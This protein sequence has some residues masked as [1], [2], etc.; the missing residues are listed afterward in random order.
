[1]R[2]PTPTRTSPRRSRALPYATPAAVLDAHARRARDCHD[3]RT[4]RSRTGRDTRRPRSVGSAVPAR[5][6]T[7]S[8]GDFAACDEL[9][10]AV[11]AEQRLRGVRGV[12]RWRRESATFPCRLRRRTRT[13]SST[14][15]TRARIRSTDPLDANTARRRRT[16]RRSR[17]ASCRCCSVR[18]TS[19]AVRLLDRRAWHALATAF[20]VPA[21]GALVTAAAALGDAADSA[22]LGGLLTFAVGV[23]IGIVGCFGRETTLHDVGRRRDRL[24]RRVGRRRRRRTR[25]ESRQ[26]TTSDLI[27]AGRRRARVRP[28]RRSCSRGWRTTLLERTPDRIDRSPE[29]LPPTAEPPAHRLGPV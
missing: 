23:A 26:A 22:M 12:V 20:V 9:W 17:S 3:R 4:G 18:S 2:S 28:R 24:G 29:P 21:V 16:T 15:E 10:D 25:A 13:T 8:D 14:D 27:G 1:M 6:E 19:R 11:G 5:A 7:A